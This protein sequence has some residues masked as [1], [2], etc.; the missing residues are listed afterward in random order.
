MAIKIVY[1]FCPYIHLFLLEPVL[2]V[3]DL[4]AVPLSR[5]LSG[6]SWVHAKSSFLAQA[7][8]CYS[9]A[10]ETL[11]I[12]LAP[13]LLEL[14][15]FCSSDSCDIYNAGAT[16]SMPIHE[17]WQDNKFPAL[18]LLND[19]RAVQCLWWGT[20]EVGCRSETTLVWTSCFPNQP[21]CWAN[22]FSIPMKTCIFNKRTLRNSY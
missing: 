2:A 12:P 5:F 15:G 11:G 14:L 18:E 4:A 3:H 19:N 1:T 8:S 21:K 13:S 10:P 17:A 6:N 9:T 22:L 20:P 7:S 16:S